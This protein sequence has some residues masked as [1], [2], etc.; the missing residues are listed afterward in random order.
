MPQARQMFAFFTTVVLMIMVAGAVVALLIE[1]AVVDHSCEP[2]ATWSDEPGELLQA[3][4][5]VSDSADTL[6]FCSGYIQ[7]LS[8]LEAVATCAE[9]MRWLRENPKGPME[10]DYCLCGNQGTPHTRVSAVAQCMEQ[11]P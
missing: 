9:V 5:T 8:S 7:T 2:A 10:R 6:C 11:R 3:S 1:W 4:P